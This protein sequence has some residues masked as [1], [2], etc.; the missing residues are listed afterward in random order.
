MAI[1]MADDNVG[2][3]NADRYK[4]VEHQL[5]GAQ[6]LLAHR[7][8][9]KLDNSGGD[10]RRRA[11]HGEVLAAAFLPGLEENGLGWS[12]KGLEHV[13]RGLGGS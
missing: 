7:D 1:V 12:Y 5:R 8:F 9:E 2:R 6:A 13:V 10:A 11:G 4:Q 3:M